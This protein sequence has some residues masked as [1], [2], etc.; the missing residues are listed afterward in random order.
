MLRTGRAGVLANQP[1]A[2]VDNQVHK[3]NN[4]PKKK[5]GRTHNKNNNTCE[6]MYV[7][8]IENKASGSTSASSSQ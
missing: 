4:H 2:L 7:T 6:Y 5:S 8:A 1:L 3:P